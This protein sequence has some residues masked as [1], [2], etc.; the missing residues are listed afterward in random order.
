[1]KLSFDYFH[2]L[3]SVEFYLCN[4]D[5]RELFPLVGFD[6]KLTLRFNDLSELTFVCNSTVTL[7]DGSDVHVDAY[8]YVETRRLIFVT[9]IGW[10]V[11]DD[12]QETDNGVAQSKS[13]TCHSLQATLRD[14]G[15]SCEERVYYFYNPADP[16][17]NDYDSENEACVPS[18]MGQLFQQLGIQ[19][20]LQQGRTDPEEPYDEW[21]ITYINQSLIGKARN[22]KSATEYGYDWIAKTVANAFEVVILFDFYYKTIQ[23]LYPSEVTQLANVVYSFNNFM[24][25][26]E[27]DENADNIIT[28]MNCNGDNCDIRAVNPTGANYICDFSYYMD[29]AGRWMSSALKTKLNAWKAAL[30]A[31]KPIYQERISD[32]RAEYEDLTKIKSS[33]TEVSKVYSDL[34]VAV[35]KKAASASSSSVSTGI[36]WCETVNFGE[37]SLDEAS[38]AH[39][40]ELQSTTIIRAYKNRPDWDSVSKVW[41]MSGDYHTGTFDECFAYLD[42]EY[43]YFIDHQGT[44]GKSYCVLNGTSEV[45]KE[46]YEVQYICKGLKRYTDISYSNTWTAKYDAVKARLQA[47]VDEKES[48]IG[49]LQLLLKQ[50]TDSTNILA[51]FSN[52]PTLL[53]ELRRYWIEGDYTS[54]NISIN[55]NTAPEDAIDLENELLQTGEVELAKVCQP[56]LQFSLQTVNC[57]N[58]YEFR[59]QME[60]LELGKV[61]A[62]ERKEGVW[63]YPALLEMSFDLDGKDTFDL[64]FAN[65]LRLDD[66]GYTYGDLLSQASSTSRQVSANW[67]NF[68][69]YSKD[70]DQIDSLLKDPLSVALRASF[71]NTTNQEFTVNES[72]ILGKKFADEIRRDSFDPEQ[73]RIQNNTIIFTDDNWETARAAFG[74]ITYSNGQGSTVTAYGLIADA[75]IGTLLIGQTLEIR[76][77]SSS[78]VL[79]STGLTIK[80]GNTTVL[81][82]DVNGNLTVRG[83]IYAGGGEIGGWN[84]GEHSIYHSFSMSGST[85]YTGINVSTEHDSH[86]ENIR[87]FFAGSFNASGSDNNPGG[88][89]AFYVN[90]A[91]ELHATNGDIAGWTFEPNGFYV[92]GSPILGGFA[93]IRTPAELVAPAIFCGA[94]DKFG[95]SAKFYVNRLGFLH[96]TSGEIGGWTISDET[97][98]KNNAGIYSGASEVLPSL[99]GSGSSPIRFFGGGTSTSTRTFSVLQDG[100]LYASAVSITGGSITLRDRSDKWVEIG[101]GGG[102]RVIDLDGFYAQ[103]GLIYTCAQYSAN[104]VRYGYSH[105]PEGGISGDDITNTNELTYY[106]SAVQLIG[107]WIG[108]VSGSIVSDQRFKTNCESLDDK[109]SALFDALSPKRFMYINGTS[110]RFHTGFIAQNV[111]NAIRQAGLSERDFAALCTFNDQDGIDYLALRYEEFIAINTWQIQLLKRR[112]AE[113]ENIVASLQ[114]E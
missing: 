105:T 77:P 35:A 14:V 61:I 32:L 45:N 82:A 92:M 34:S 15:V 55:E 114:N 78:I 57:M 89:P 106:G 85:R 102:L 69:E 84:I 40:S 91:G 87:A 2:N 90:Q 60:E 51:F 113:L 26:I 67:Q 79:N 1:M 25:E 62:V 4:P 46:T 33:L 31:A 68:T 36:V 94:D 72:G 98:T 11:I 7:S 112:V 108:N 99:V 39:D 76:N 5:G 97:I 70:K 73:I 17:D 12:V 81:H 16:F 13:V 18:V 101:T 53:R 95:T 23:V 86:P 28:V 19:Q 10:F 75:V 71:A 9:D 50:I 49:D 27:I 30:E 43:K 24:K 21:T 20:N 107:D 54:D 74:K 37:R 38:F 103:S 64:K 8:D 66:W 52:T 80:N 41:V 6:R 83:T 111:R 47:D 3:E 56:K 110:H 104:V 48:S 100:S 59:Q 96:S 109:Y 42:S 58:Q 44:T 88:S 65:A 22:F 63:Y 29:D 93:G